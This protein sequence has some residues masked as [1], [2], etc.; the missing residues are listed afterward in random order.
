VNAQPMP[1]PANP[2]PSN[3]VQETI[4]AMLNAP[5]PAPNGGSDGGKGDGM[6]KPIFL[7]T[8]AQQQGISPEDFGT[9]NHP[10][11]TVRADLYSLNDNTAYPYRPAGKLFFKIGASPHFSRGLM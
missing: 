10:F 9:N 11:T 7:G 3:T 2:L 5:A 1:L 8:P 6:T 4:E